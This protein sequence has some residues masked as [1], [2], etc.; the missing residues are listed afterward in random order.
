MV[1]YSNISVKQSS[2]SVD[3][4]HL[5]I[6]IIRHAQD[7]NELNGEGIDKLHKVVN[8]QELLFDTDPPEKQTFRKQLL[9]NLFALARA[10]QSVKNDERGKL[11]FYLVNLLL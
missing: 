3:R 1:S 6:G 7:P 10:E 9:E 4:I 8:R 5:A 11:Y 2:S